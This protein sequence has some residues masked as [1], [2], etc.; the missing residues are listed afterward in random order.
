MIDDFDYVID[1][2]EENHVSQ[3]SRR[4]YYA[5]ALKATARLFKEGLLSEDEKFHL[6][7]LILSDDHRIAAAIECFEFDHNGEEMLDTFLRIAKLTL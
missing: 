2:E 3:L 7:T 6:K 5:I 1:D 4:S